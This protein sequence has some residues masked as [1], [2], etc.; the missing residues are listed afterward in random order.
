LRRGG[1]S[2]RTGKAGESRDIERGRGIT[3][4]RVGGKGGEREEVRG[5]RDGMMGGREV[6][7][8]EKM[9]ACIKG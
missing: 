3:Y 1:G 7:G 2:S 4:R 9:G 8:G 6:G 5:S